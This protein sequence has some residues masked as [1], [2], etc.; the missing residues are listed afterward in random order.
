MLRAGR[1]SR[2]FFLWIGG[3]SSSN[4]GIGMGSTRISGLSTVQ[5]PSVIL[6]GTPIAFLTASLSHLLCGSNLLVSG[7]LNTPS[8]VPMK[9]SALLFRH[10]KPDFVLVLRIHSVHGVHGDLLCQHLPMKRDKFS[11]WL[12]AMQSFEWLLPVKIFLTSGQDASCR[13]HQLPPT[14]ADLASRPWVLLVC[15]SHYDI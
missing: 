2:L 9:H 7:A 8:A 12:L 13:F 3:P 14:T 5:L 1:V 11:G 6:Q 10:S 4:G 15:S